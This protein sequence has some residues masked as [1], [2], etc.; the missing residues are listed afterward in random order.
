MQLGQ[1]IS[2]LIDN[3]L[4]Y[5]FKLIIEHTLYLMNNITYNITIS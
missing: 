5:I 3:N 2:S 1:L 4:N